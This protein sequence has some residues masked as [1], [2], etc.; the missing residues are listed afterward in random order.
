MGS[1][2]PQDLETWVDQLGDQAVG[3]DEMMNNPPWLNLPT[4]P[5]RKEGGSTVGPLDTRGGGGTG[6]SGECL[7]GRHT[8]EVQ[9]VSGI[10]GGFQIF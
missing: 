10:E 2:D 3:R 4:Q 8:R 6:G 1:L 9:P 7:K 5:P